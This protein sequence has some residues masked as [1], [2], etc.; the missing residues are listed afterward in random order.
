[1]AFLLASAPADAVKNGDA[2]TSKLKAA[3]LVGAPLWLVKITST[4]SVVVPEGRLH[5][6]WMPEVLTSQSME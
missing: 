4:A 3:T 1:L 6:V 5:V 2:I